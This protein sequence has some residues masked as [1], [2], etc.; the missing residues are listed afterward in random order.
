MSHPDESGK[1]LE[2]T[3][4]EKFLATEYQALISLDTA[5]NQRLD[6]LITLYM[7]IAAAPWALL[8][9][10]LKDRPLLPTIST[11]PPLVAW[12]F[13]LTGLLGAL[14]AMIRIQVGFNIVLY[15]RNV[16]AIRGYFL[17]KDT[18]LSFH[19]PISPKVPPYY[20]KWEDRHLAL[21]GTAFVN[22]LYIALGLFN[23]I[24]WKERLALRVLAA[25][26]V[27]SLSFVAHLIYYRSQARQ[28]E[29]RNIGK[30]LSFSGK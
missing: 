26:L 10:L 7:T 25:A 18:K 11:I 6:S 22:S 21:I 9:F 5:R 15:M 20:S 13:I 1:S 27:A 16:N 12:A 28:R 8:S 14:V 19:L 29:S 30:H 23:L 17:E 2:D 4:E 3:K 24:G